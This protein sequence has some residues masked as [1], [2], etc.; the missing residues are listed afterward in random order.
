M[1]G[2]RRSRNQR[3]QRGAGLRGGNWVRELS[4]GKAGE[5]SNQEGCRQVDCTREVVKEDLIHGY[6]EHCWGSRIRI[7]AGASGTVVPTTL[8]TSSPLSD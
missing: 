5:L 8:S 2:R 4:K 3:L 7:L 1:L 6:C